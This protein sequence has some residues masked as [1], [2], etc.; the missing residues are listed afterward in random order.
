MN[1]VRRVS[2]AGAGVEVRRRRTGV[3]Y[4]RYPVVWELLEPRILWAVDV[5]ALAVTEAGIAYG[6]FDSNGTVRVEGGLVEGTRSIVVQG[7]GKIIL[8][9]WSAA[10]TPAGQVHKDQATSVTLVRLNRGGTIDRSFGADGFV[11]FDSVH[12]HWYYDA[13]PLALQAD[14]KLLVGGDNIRRFNADGSVDTSF[15]ANGVVTVDSNAGLVRTLAVTGGGKIVAAGWEYNVFQF[16]ADGSL[17]VDFATSDEAWDFS[18]PHGHLTRVMVQADGK[19]LMAGQRITGG[20]PDDPMVTVQMLVRLNAD[21]TVDTGFGD[22]GIV[23]QPARDGNQLD[24]T[25]ATLQPDGK[26]LVAGYGG[27]GGIVVRYNPDGSLDESFGDDGMYFNEDGGGAYDIAVDHEG[28]IVIG[29]SYNGPAAWRINGDGTPDPTFGRFTKPLDSDYNFAGDSW[30]LAV[31]PDGDV[32]LTGQS[33]VSALWL[34]TPKA[35]GLADLYI[36]RISGGD[37]DPEPP[38]EETNPPP[39][40]PPPPPAPE[41][42][43]PDPEAPQ[44]AEPRSALAG[45]FGGNGVVRTDATGGVERAQEV[46]VQGD[47][48]VIV[49]GYSGTYTGQGAEHLGPDNTETH[50]T[51]VR[52]NL[53]G[54]LDNSFGNGGVATV[55]ARNLVGMRYDNAELQAALQSDGKIVVGGTALHRFNAD[56]SVDTSFGDN[57]AAATDLLLV[58]ALAILPNGKIAIS[59]RYGFVFALY[60]S[61]GTLDTSFG[62]AARSTND[63]QLGVAPGNVSHEP[64]RAVAGWSEIGE[65]IAQPDGKIIAVGTVRTLP[66][67][68]YVTQL[69]VIRM[70]GDGSLDGSFGD[71]GVV[72]TKVPGHSAAEGWAVALQADG[73]IVVSGAGA[74]G[75]LARYNADGSLDAKFGNAGL[76]TTNREGAGGDVAVQADGKIVITTAAGAAR[77]HADGSFDRAFNAPGNPGGVA[78]AIAPDGDIVVA[79]QP[80]SLAV[81][82]SSDFF[83]ARFDGEALLPPETG[84]GGMFNDTLFAQRQR[85]QLLDDD[86]GA[87]GE[88]GLFG[89]DDEEEDKGAALPEIL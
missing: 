69:Y 29:G 64:S 7:D 17:D 38:G 84:S 37:S 6:S 81:G 58:D 74:R 60:N 42:P 75:T 48:K 2:V 8:A 30:A 45:D 83:V 26:I 5:G 66:H 11:R 67:D 14:G 16:N 1:V 87:F 49:I 72:M 32:L 62:G 20:G 80:T 55:P 19:I 56:G 57:G 33:G 68:T 12:Q 36:T 61:D 59:T 79:G 76:L 41:P 78:V 53:D 4:E 9:A 31:E 40:P 70:N 52:Y 23:L 24:G 50:I 39:P 35:E 15:G 3:E 82:A 86:G 46:L 51:L 25:A 21:G 47:G 71:G 22:N 63:D 73:K 85:I 54:S 44:P 10:K 77:Y 28:R 27:N 34:N 13:L 88:D 43:G 18:Y 89:D 65:M